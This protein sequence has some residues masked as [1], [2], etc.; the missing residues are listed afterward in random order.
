MW[1]DRKDA[2]LKKIFAG[3]FQQSGI[4]LSSDN[5]IVDTSSF[6][7]RPNLTHQAPVA[8]PDSKLDDGSRLRDREQVRAFECRVRI[9]AEDLFEMGGRHLRE[10]LC[11]NLDGFDR[12]CAGQGNGWDGPGWSRAALTRPRHDYALTVG[13]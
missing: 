11:I 1:R 8:V 7:A 4:S 10:N 3:V 2:G 9:V 13:R 5:L 6:F 12:Q